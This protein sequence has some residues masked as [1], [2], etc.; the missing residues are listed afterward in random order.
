MCGFISVDGSAPEHC[1]VCGAP[2]KA[3]NEKDNAITDPSDATDKVEANKK[4]IPSIT[5]EKKCGLIEGCTDVHV[6]IGET[7]HPMLPEHFIMFIDCYLDKKFI[8]RIRLTPE[9]LNPAVGMHLKVSSGKFAAIEKC[10]IH[11]YWIKETEL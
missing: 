7:T 3:F 5:V 11:G 6:K 1:P 2:K 4:H 9:K 8:S 10:N